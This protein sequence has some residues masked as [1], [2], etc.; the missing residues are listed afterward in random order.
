MKRST[1]KLID[2]HRPQQQKVKEDPSASNR[3][4]KSWACICTYLSI[5]TQEDSEVDL[6]Y[7]SISFYTQVTSD[8]HPKYFD[9]FMFRRQQ[10]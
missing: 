10:L 4:R 2:V 5:R 1:W 6:I 7:H 9:F 3:S 8:L